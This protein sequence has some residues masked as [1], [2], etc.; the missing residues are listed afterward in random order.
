MET[1]TETPALADRGLFGRCAAA[2]SQEE[3]N[4]NDIMGWPLCVAKLSTQMRCASE[5][6]E[7]GTSLLLV[8]L[9]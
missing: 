8:F 9:G 1:I 3:H 2:F 6:V 5:T 7:K 4:L